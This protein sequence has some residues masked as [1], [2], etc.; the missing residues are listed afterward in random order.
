M[1]LVFTSNHCVLMLVIKREDDQVCVLIACSVK[2]VRVIFVVMC[3]Y[4]EWLRSILAMAKYM[5]MHLVYMVL[6]IP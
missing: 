4:D 5:F 1:L 6:T 2:K 3:H